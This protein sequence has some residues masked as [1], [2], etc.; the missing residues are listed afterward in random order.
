MRCYNDA[1]LAREAQD[2]DLI[3]GGHDHDYYGVTQI[4]KSVV[5]KSGSDFRELTKIVIT[6][7][8][9][10]TAK[11]DSEDSMP[12]SDDSPYGG[13]AHCNWD[14]EDAPLREAQLP[15]HHGT[16]ENEIVQAKACNLV[17]GNRGGGSMILPEY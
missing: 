17:S 10:E 15:Q 2:I 3:M 8:P 14:I 5:I 9:A 13:S 1:R 11:S 12:D 16:I 4:G 6:P 7:Q